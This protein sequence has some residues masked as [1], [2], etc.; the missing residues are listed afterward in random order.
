MGTSGPFS[1]LA[2]VSIQPDNQYT[3]YNDTTGAHGYAYYAQ[4]LNSVTGDLSGSSSVF[5]PGGPTYYSLQKL[6]Q[7][8]KDKLYSAGYIRDDT[9]INDWINEWYELMTNAAIKV[10][11][12][13]LL[14]TNMFPYAQ[15]NGLGTVTDPSYKQADQI[16]SVT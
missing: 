15:S 3:Q 9:L 8:V 16:S 1:A 7:R 6:R 5:I 12:G 10:N 14:G 4:Y 13:Y 11:Q 2:T